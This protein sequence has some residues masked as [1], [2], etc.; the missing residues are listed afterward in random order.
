[1]LFYQKGKKSKTYRAWNYIYYFVAE[2][3]PVLAGTILYTVPY[4]F[5]S[6][7]Y[8]TQG[9][10]SNV[11]IL[12]H[13]T[14]WFAGSFIFVLSLVGCIY[15]L[16]KKT[17][18]LKVAAISTIICKAVL[19]SLGA[20]FE[21]SGRT[22]SVSLV[23]IETFLWPFYILFC[24]IILSI[25]LKLPFFQ[26]SKFSIVVRNYVIILPILVSLSQSLPDTNKRFWNA[27][28]IPLKFQTICNLLEEISISKMK[29]SGE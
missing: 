23:N 8:S 15:A 17:G 3:L 29:T 24:S 27:W 11:S 16:L 7:L 25:V 20:F 2:R 21:W 19:L 14:T 13:S 26:Y 4:F 5:H 28:P 10:W 6:E 22:P 12:F 9:G 1:M 18:T